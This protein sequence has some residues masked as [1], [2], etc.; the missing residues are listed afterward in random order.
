MAD[1]LVSDPTDAASTATL[2]SLAQALN[3][4][5]ESASN[6]ALGPGNTLE[7]LVKDMIRP[8]LKEWLDQNLPQLVERMVK[9]EIERMV[10]RAEDN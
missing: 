8:M 7:D 10:R 6:I 1:K 3:R 4:E 5:Q 2:S 9:R